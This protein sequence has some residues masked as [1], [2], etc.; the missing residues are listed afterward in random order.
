MNAGTLCCHLV[1][2]FCTSLPI[3]WTANFFFFLNY[4]SCSGQSSAG[5]IFKMA[6]SVG[7][8]I[9]FSPR[10]LQAAAMRFIKTVRLTS[11][12]QQETAFAVSRK[13]KW[14]SP[15]ERTLVPLARAICPCHLLV[16]LVGANAEIS[17]RETNNSGSVVLDGPSHHSH[18]WLFIIRKSDIK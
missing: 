6:T 7:E 9:A 15:F 14:L 11:L 1:G 2:D 17:R 13:A 18:R 5:C 3:A 8:V 12:Y 4:S 10:V 16:P